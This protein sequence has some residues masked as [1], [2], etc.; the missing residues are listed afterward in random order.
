VTYALLLLDVLVVVLLVELVVLG[1]VWL[2]RRRRRSSRRPAAADTRPRATATE[3]APGFG[4]GFGT[5]ER[6]RR[7]ENCRSGWTGR[8]NS[9]ASVLTLWVRRAARRRARR[10]GRPAPAW[11]AR[12]GWNRCPSCFSTAVRDSTRQEVGAR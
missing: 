7:C 2:L 8:P 11:A 10:R 9:D 3:T 1:P 12:Q 6:R 4:I 5:G